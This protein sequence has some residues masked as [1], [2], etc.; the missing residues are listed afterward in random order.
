[1]RAGV[2]GR[3][4]NNQLSGRLNSCGDKKGCISSFN[5]ADE[6]N[7][8]PPW[9]YNSEFTIQATSSFDARK[10]Q[11]KA[12]ARA[13][14]AAA[15]ASAAGDDASSAA[16]PAAAAPAAAPKGKSID[17]AFGELK[18][19]VEAAGGSVQKAADR[20][21]LAE[22]R[23]HAPHAPRERARARVQGALVSFPAC[24]H[25]RRRVVARRTV[26]RLVHRPDR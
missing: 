22:V 7:Y 4:T 9:T 16:A 6:P 23:E 5:Q 11:L 15:A 3:G 25:S 2:I 17:D 13:E 12:Q 21:L 1:M 19:A 10:E 18:T 26:Y 8:V 14:A 20:Y 24:W